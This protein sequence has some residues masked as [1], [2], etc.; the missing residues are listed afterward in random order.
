MQSRVLTLTRRAPVV[1]VSGVHCHPTH[2][3]QVAGLLCTSL[4]STAS[5]TVVQHLYFKA[6][7]SGSK[8]ENSGEVASTAKKCQETMTETKVEITQWSKVKR[9][10]MWLALLTCAIPPSA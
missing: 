3:L 5:S 4:C 9:W 10:S 2:P 8:W 1:H 6:R 7:I